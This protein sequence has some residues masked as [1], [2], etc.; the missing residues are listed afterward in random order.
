MLIK[1]S[2]QCGET[3][4]FPHSP[5]AWLIFSLT[6]GNFVLLK[7]RGEFFHYCRSLTIR[8]F[9]SRI[10]CWPYY[11][12]RYEI[13]SIQCICQI[14]I[15]LCCM[16]RL[17]NQLPRYHGYNVYISYKNAFKLSWR[18]SYIFG[19]SIFPFGGDNYVPFYNNFRF[20]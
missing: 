10:Q 2:F 13:M 8:I 9:D 14:I 15:N 6:H 17:Q 1:A 18:A 19:C 20:M 5:C 3:W 7:K 16:S 11:W 12:L 4:Y